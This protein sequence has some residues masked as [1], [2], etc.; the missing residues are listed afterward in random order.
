[1]RHKARIYLN[2][3]VHAMSSGAGISLAS[4]LAEGSS[5]HLVTG[6]EE[7]EEEEEG[8]VSYSS[9]DSDRYESAQSEGAS[10]SEVVDATATMEVLM[11]CMESEPLVCTTS[12]KH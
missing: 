6:E 3:V 1:M 9:G 12:D 5:R 11:Y 10:M 2:A 8:D 7:R 4:V